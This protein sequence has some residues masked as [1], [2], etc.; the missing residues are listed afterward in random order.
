MLN[1]YF[2]Y[3]ICYKIPSTMKL[4]IINIISFFIISYFIYLNIGNQSII[5]IWFFI[6]LAIFFSFRSFKLSDVV[7][8]NYF[9]KNIIILFVDTIIFMVIACLNK[10]LDLVSLGILIMCIIIV[11]FFIYIFI[12]F[13]KNF[14][15]PNINFIS[16]FV[17]INALINQDYKIYVEEGIINN[18]NSEFVILETTD[19][20]V[21][22]NKLFCLIDNDNS[23]SYKKGT[24]IFIEVSRIEKYLKL[25]FYSKKYK[26]N[27]K[28]LFNNNLKE[29][30][31]I[32]QTFSRKE[33]KDLNPITFENKSISSKHMSLIIDYTFASNNTEYIKKINDN[34]IILLSGEH[35]SGKTT[36]LKKIF[37]NQ[38]NISI[39]NEGV[40]DDPLSIIYN[41]IKNN[42][43]GSKL[44]ATKIKVAKTNVLTIFV[45]VAFLAFLKMDKLIRFLDIP[46]YQFEFNLKNL[47]ICKMF[48]IFVC[49]IIFFIILFI[50]KLFQ[51]EILL[52][53]KGT[54]TNNRRI[55]LKFIENIMLDY[56]LELVIEDF[57]RT[58]E[59]NVKK[60][61]PEIDALAQFLKNTT[62]ESKIIVTTTIESDDNNN[63]SDIDQE[64]QKRIF[65][66]KIPFNSKKIDFYK[67]KIVKI[68]RKKV[69]NVEKIEEISNKEFSSYTDLKNELKML[70]Y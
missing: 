32:S 19:E 34:K 28:M 62:N 14:T 9:L 46:I 15:R 29:K 45:A 57:D 16:N 54:T 60:W 4:M 39:W 69:N 3:K 25:K 27:Y 61:I 10:N 11:I 7:Q 53:Q 6:F 37:P 20:I 30:V 22:N 50:V 56:P 8:E 35:G 36:F 47:I 2:L 70:L 41:N 33:K 58:T 12:S 43:F 21:L 40:E 31:Y 68:L 63:Y 65:Q 5:Y 38:I 48:I 18:D 52:Y 66:I 64:S 1:K 17:D 49:L 59:E 55:F 44:F 67:E 26:K 24:L 42:V 23:N 13:F 51:Y